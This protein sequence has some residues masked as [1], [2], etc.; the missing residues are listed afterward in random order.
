MANQDGDQTQYLALLLPHL[1]LGEAEVGEQ[2]SGQPLSDEG[3]YGVKQGSTKTHT[4][5]PEP[6]GKAIQRL[7]IA[8]LTTLTNE[9]NDA[10]ALEARGQLQQAQSAWQVYF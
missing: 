8:P 1:F 6:K 5:A 10:E 9:W 4:A 3:E 2:K 7:G